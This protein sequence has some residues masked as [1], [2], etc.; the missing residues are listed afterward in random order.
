MQK[1]SLSAVK[2]RLRRG[3]EKLAQT[4]GADLALEYE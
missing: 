4:L 2:Q 1:D 3:R